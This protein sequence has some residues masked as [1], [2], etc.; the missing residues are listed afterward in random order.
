MVSASGGTTSG[1]VNEASSFS[2][3][4]FCA[5]D[6]SRFPSSRLA[7][8]I[9]FRMCAQ[10]AGGAFRSRSGIVEF[11]RKSR[12]KLSQ[13]SQA[14]SLLFEAGGF[15]DA[16]G[17]QAHQTLGQLRHFLYKIWKQRGGK[18]QGA[19]VRL[20][21]PAHSKL[22]HP[23]KRQYSGNVARLQVKDERFRPQVRPALEVAPQESQTSHRLDRL[24]A[25][26]LSP[27]LRFISC[28][29]LMNQSI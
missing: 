25:S 7:S 9:F 16:V 2:I 24:A 26:R 15:A 22:L 12:R 13:R 4:D 14:V 27:A 8:L 20:G 17:H 19:A 1:C 21:S 11:M 5:D 18:S 6:R 3:S 29:W 28:D 23:R 10:L